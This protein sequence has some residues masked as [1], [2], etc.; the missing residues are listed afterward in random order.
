MTTQRQQKNESRVHWRFRDFRFEETP[1]EKRITVHWR[2]RDFRFEETESG[3]PEH[4]TLLLPV[5]IIISFA[6]GISMNRKVEI[7]INDRIF[8]T[9]SDR[10]AQVV[11]QKHDLKQF[12]PSNRPQAQARVNQKHAL[13]PKTPNPPIISRGTMTHARKNLSF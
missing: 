7:I 11:N 3:T 13:H 8:A 1:T 10:G 6:I 2:F 5:D 12:Q 4:L 9:V